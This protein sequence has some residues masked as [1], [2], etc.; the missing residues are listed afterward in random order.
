[1]SMPVTM[2]RAMG[3]TRRRRESLEQFLLASLHRSA[4]T[5]PLQ[6]QEAVDKQVEGERGGAHPVLGCLLFRHLAADEYLAVL[7]PHGVGEDIR[8]V[9]LAAQLPIQALGSCGGYENERDLPA[10]EHSL[11]Y[12]LVA[13]RHY[14]FPLPLTRRAVGSIL[15]SLTSS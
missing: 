3:Y 6:V 5:P 11:G 2:R 7:G 15:P 10:R 8:C 14:F 9:G 13:R 12:A 1:M 4:M